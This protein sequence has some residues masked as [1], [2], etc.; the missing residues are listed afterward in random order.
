MF[1]WSPDGSQIAYHFETASGE[2]GDRLM[3]LDLATERIEDIG[4][5]GSGTGPIWSPD[6]HSLAYLPRRR[7]SISFLTL[8][9]SSVRTM[10]LDGFR[11][12]SIL[13]SPGSDSLVI[14]ARRVDGTREDGLWVTSIRQPHLTRLEVENVNKL[15]Q[16]GGGLIYFQTGRQFL[17]ISPDGGIPE[18]F[19]TLDDDC[20]A[21]PPYN[22]L[23]PDLVAVVCGSAP[24]RTDLMIVRG[25]DAD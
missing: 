14:E 5:I 7:D 6:G 13:F 12:N 20:G 17:R 25:F 9:D 18:V 19:A 16:W 1:E 24:I 10:P 21:D 11:G 8:A 3:V 22:T 2:N 23:A 4:R 15:L